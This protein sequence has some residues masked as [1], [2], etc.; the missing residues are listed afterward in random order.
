[1][2]SSQANA[3]YCSLPACPALSTSYT[4]VPPRSCI[5]RLLQDD[6][7]PRAEDIECL[8]KLLST[9]GQQLESP[10]VKGKAGMS[11]QAVSNCF[12]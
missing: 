2:P 1:M 11:Q 9:V 6:Q 8:C 3:H 5:Q 12:I 4:A 7:N 10:Q